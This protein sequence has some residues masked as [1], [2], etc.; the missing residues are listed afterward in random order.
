MPLLKNHL[1]FPDLLW[2]K[3]TRFLG[4]HYGILGGAMTWISD[5]QLV[6]AI[7]NAGGFGVL[8]CGAL[9]PDMLAQEIIKTQ[10]R[11]SNP[12]GVNLIIFHHNIA[13]LIRV[14]GECHVSHVFLGGGV[15]S[16]D[17]I[18]AL[19]DWGI[20][21]VGFCPSAMVGKRMIKMGIEALVIEGNEAGGHVGP[22]ATQVLAQEILPL[23]DV[24]I[25]VAGGIGSGLSILSYLLMGASG[26]QMGTRF[27]CASESGAHPRFKEAF[28]KAHSRDAT[29]SVQIDPRFPVIPVRALENDGKKHFLMAQKEAIEAYQNGLLTQQEAQMKIELFWAG[30][31]RRAVIDGDIE[32]GSLMAGQ[33]VGLVKEIKPC[34]DIIQSL[35]EEMRQHWQNLRNAGSI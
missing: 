32:E 28:I 1:T 19:R 31:L 20:K 34:H 35:L 30:A 23:F 12:F 21:V 25:F 7:S 14:C 9:K 22:V 15:P 16:Q 18:T 27:V 29:L 17:M 8:A 33:S 13:D 3:G 24:P 6:S 5:H 2:E 4:S 26:C 11:T 10:E